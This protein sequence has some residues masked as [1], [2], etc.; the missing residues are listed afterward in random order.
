MGYDG[1][2][3]VKIQKG[4]DANAAWRSLKNTP[5]ILEGFVNFE[6]EISVVAARSADGHVECFEVTENEHRDHILKI[7]T[8]PAKMSPRSR[9]KPNASPPTSPRLSIMSA[10]WRSRCSW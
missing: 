2:G 8:V 1:K 9:P 4:D 6:R 10:C 5:C 7:S 3:Q